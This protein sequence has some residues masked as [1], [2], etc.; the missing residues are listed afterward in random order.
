MDLRWLSLLCLLGLAAAAQ[1]GSHPANP[2]RVASARTLTAGS[3]AE[4]EKA[5]EPFL[6]EKYLTTVRYEDDGTGEKD[7]AV[8][9]RVE[10]AAGAQQLHS[11]VFHYNSASERMNVRYLRV[12]KP[13]GATV[14]A[15]TDAVK[16]VPVSLASAALAYVDARE[17]RIAIPA[18]AVG[19]TVEYEIVTQIVKPPA[20]GEFWFQHNFLRGEPPRDE[21]LE[22]SLPQNRTVIVKSPGYA[23]QVASAPGRKIYRWTRDVSARPAKEE[24]STQGATPGKASPLDV[25]IT[26]FH[27]WDEVARWYA[28]LE[29]GGAQPASG[30]RE[31]TAALIRGSSTDLAKTQ[32]IYEFVA[33][34]I[35]YVALPLGR[36]SYAP[37]P[38]AEVLS[39]GYGDAKDKQALLAAMLRSA[40]V[41]SDAVLLPY[42][43]QLDSAVPSP[44]QFD[45]VIAA[46]HIGGDLVWMDPTVDVAPFRLLAAPLR[47]KSALLVSADG[48][49]RLVLTPADPPFPSVQDVSI[50][51]Q[52]SPL[53]KLTA[54]AHYSLRG[55]TELA[56][57]LAFENTP[58]TQWKELGQTILAYDGIQGEVS[59][60]RPGAPADTIHPFEFELD[61][62]APGF[63]T[64]PAK[65]AR[66]AMPLLTIGL[67]SMPPDSSQPVRLGSPLSVTVHLRLALPADFSAQPPV[68]VSVARDYAEFRSSYHFAAGVLTAERTVKFK[69]R[70]LP[71]ARASD[72]LAFTRA[73][74][75]DQSQALIIENL[76]PGQP[77]IPSSVTPNDLLEAA[78]AALRGGQPRAAIPLFERLVELDPRRPQAWN[79]LGLAYL[80]TGN[81]PQAARA[82]RK[83]IEFNP[84]DENVYNYL[85]VALERQQDFDGAAATFRKQTE[86]NPLDP[87]AHAALGEILLDRQN[88]AEAVPELEKAAVL[89]ADKPAIQ[90]AL[91]RAYLNI[92]QNKKALAAFARAAE[93]SPSAPVWNEIAYRLARHKADLDTAHKF[94]ESAVSAVE[95]DLQ[96][97]DLS[98][99]T[100][101][102]MADVASLAPYWDTL[103][104]VYFQ[105]GD[106]EAAE[107]YVR[108]AWRLGLDGTPGDH[109]AQIYEKRGQKQQAIDACALALAAPNALPETR[110]RLTLLLGGNAGIADLVKQA[111]KELKSLRVLPVGKSEGEDARASFLV[112]LSP[113]TDGPRIEG[114]RF[115]DGSERLRS[116]GE[117]LR[118]LDYGPVFPDRSPVKILRR[119]TLSCSQVAGVCM[120]TLDRPVDVVSEQ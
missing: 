55:D 70:E 1:E 76:A 63:F 25:E 47:H 95:G 118:T 102:Q 17:E 73:V 101:A 52:V 46:A 78:L 28:G 82:F 43:R 53:G 21:R 109:L 60:A 49:G 14:T 111:S 62:S 65:N 24:S 3:S 33:Q 16:D 51:G 19:D 90:I 41:E 107:R 108:A 69:M 64:W 116:L 89:S 11:L 6:I 79:D 32:A 61:F 66:A 99:P 56:L 7:L 75:A 54:R 50:E 30:I 105:Q 44:S 40:G 86:R 88:Y 22:I 35:R 72:Y 110:A 45:H 71:A 2:G 12:R 80:Q 74:T 85:G 96:T 115:L 114:V 97:L 36:I 4:K 87:L 26:S 8:R 106:L 20:P 23:F 77:S 100:A 42:G 68:G 59:A 119:G 120:F 84:A 18:L 112:L 13:D 31:K 103:G 98:K 92:G 83:Q 27:N 37:R 38:P 39:S 5:Q 34:K 117:R 15:G 81:Y 104:W 67:P 91:G 57:R 58:Q 113:G 29:K 94:A 9:I 10:T 48:H 93:L